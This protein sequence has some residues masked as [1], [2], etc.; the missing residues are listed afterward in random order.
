MRWQGRK[1][2]TSL[3]QATNERRYFTTG[4]KCTTRATAR[5]ATLILYSLLSVIATT[6]V[7]MDTA[8]VSGNASA[9]EQ[10]ASFYCGMTI[11]RSA[12]LTADLGPCPDNGIEIGASNI[13]LDC[14]GHAITG[15]DNNTGQGI[16]SAGHSKVTISN[17]KVGGFINAFFIYNATETMLDGSV[18]MENNVGVALKNVANITLARNAATNNSAD[19]IFV[20]NA[21]GVTI[22]NNR[23]VQNDETGFYVGASTNSSLI[24]N[25][26]AGNGYGYFL[27]NSTGNKLDTN[28]ATGNIN[29]GFHFYEFSDNALHANTARDNKFGGFYLSFSKNNTLINN[30]SIG[31]NEAFYLVNSTG[32]NMTGNRALGDGATGIAFHFI[33][34]WMTNS[35]SNPNS[36]SS[37]DCS[38]CSTYSRNFVYQ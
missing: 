38:A 13:H 23:S 16:T 37:R 4:E 11:M 7:T 31:S 18:A 22:K 35:N 19:G 34:G 26:A 14:N 24:Q 28:N 29:E 25:V 1:N 17:C 20:L 2:N 32:N 3:H 9:A 12:N 33:P 8:N 6:T 15:T 5:P 10:Q 27:S 21:T 30:T 36:N